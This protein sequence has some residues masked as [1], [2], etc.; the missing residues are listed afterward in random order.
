MDP[1]SEELKE[2]I[3][4]LTDAQLLQIVTVEANAYRPEAVEFA[5]AELAA[6][7]VDYSQ[8]QAATAPALDLPSAV[9]AGPDSAR[10]SVSVCASCGGP[11]RAGTL[12]AEKELTIV[13]GDNHEERFL[14]VTACTQCS[15]VWLFADFETDVQA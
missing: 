3:C 6:R 8:P 7:R 2:R 10:T 1:E 12:V 9:P 13:F 11:L 4:G 15:L 14:L 5:R